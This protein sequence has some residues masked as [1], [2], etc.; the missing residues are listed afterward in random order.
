M[1]LNPPGFPLDRMFL[2]MVTLSSELRAQ[3]TMPL[4]PFIG[5][6]MSALPI[7]GR[8]WMLSTVVDRETWT[9]FSAF[10]SLLV[11]MCIKIRARSCYK[12]SIFQFLVLNC[13]FMLYLVILEIDQTDRY[14]DRQ[15]NVWIVRRMYE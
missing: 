7:T 1:V 6:L 2:E 10:H 13:F 5:K 11:K 14:R 12:C 4:Q 9:L 3:S 8:L 15:I